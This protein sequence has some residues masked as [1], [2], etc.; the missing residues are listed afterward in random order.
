MESF[1]YSQSMTLSNDNN[2]FNTYKKKWTSE[3]ANSSLKK[4]VINLAQQAF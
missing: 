1:I 4:K 3:S 2:S